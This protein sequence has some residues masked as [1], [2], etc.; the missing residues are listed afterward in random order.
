[1]ANPNSVKYHFAGKS[2][3]LHELYDRLLTMLSKFGLIVEE[4]KKTSIHLVNVSALAGVEVRQNYLLLNIKTD[5]PID[6]PR[7]E[8]SER[9]SAR[10]FHH[11]VRITTAVEIDD[12]LRRWL[13]DAYN[14]S[15]ARSKST[16]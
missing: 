3:L 7:I 15:V 13:K 5:Y 9:I 4:S 6:N 10:R 1:M 11:R 14:L 2:P 12:E 16:A 8:K